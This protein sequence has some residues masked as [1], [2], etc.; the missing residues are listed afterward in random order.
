[1]SAGIQAWRTARTRWFVV[2]NS[3]NFLESWGARRPNSSENFAIYG[4]KTSE[5]S[6][7]S[8]PGLYALFPLYLTKIDS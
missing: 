1:M 5:F 7:I 8:T 2:N 6:Q 4:Y 3:R